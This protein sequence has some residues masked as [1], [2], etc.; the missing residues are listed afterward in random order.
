MPLELDLIYAS[1]RGDTDTVWWKLFQL[2]VLS[3]FCKTPFD[4]NFPS[5]GG[6]PALIRA[7][8]NGHTEVVGLLLQNDQV[9]VNTVGE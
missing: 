6:E 3:F 4:I 8:K 1:E 2:R 7:V 5:S 9:D